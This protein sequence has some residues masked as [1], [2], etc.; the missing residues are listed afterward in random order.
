MIGEWRLFKWQRLANSDW[1]NGANNPQPIMSGFG[2][3]FQVRHI[4]DLRRLSEVGV[5]AKLLKDNS[6]SRNF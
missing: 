2:S 3:A 5:S 6:H 4:F 1:W